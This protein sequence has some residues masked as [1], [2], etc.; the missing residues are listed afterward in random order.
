MKKFMLG[1]ITVIALTF[2]ANAQKYYSKDGIV[3]F[4]ATSKG[5]PENI[6]GKTTKGTLVID[7]ATGAVE[8]GV[9]IKS[10]HFERALMEEHFNENYMQSDKF[11]DA[12]FKGTI[13]DFS[14]VNLKKDGTYKVNVSGKLTMHGVTKDIKTTATLTVAGGAISAAKTNL[15]TVLADYGIEVPSL[16][17]DK[18]ASEAKI[19]I[20]AA[21]KP[22]PAK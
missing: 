16:V 12:K 1:F 17:K 4:D 18:L 2:Q 15:S 7:A 11:K 9:L 21:L 13:T 3:S 14:S 8:M 20:S 6:D 22:L 19:E 10:F 5:S